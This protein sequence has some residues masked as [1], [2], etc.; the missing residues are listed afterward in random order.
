M[1]LAECLL[2]LFAIAEQA[3]QHQEQVDEIEVE[4]KGAHKRLFAHDFA[5]I[6]FKIHFLDLLGVIGCEADKDQN[7][8]CRDRKFEHGRC[9]ENIDDSGNDQTDEA[10]HQEGT[11]AGKIA[12]G[13]VAIKA[14][15]AKCCGGDE[16]HT[17]NGSAGIDHENGR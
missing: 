3:Q 2:S 5:A 7:A 9:Q 16:E 17:R 10:H 4:A 6:A 11:H 8:D 13:G 12:L 1:L 14:H 15:G